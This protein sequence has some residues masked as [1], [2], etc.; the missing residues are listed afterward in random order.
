MTG[1]RTLN[2]ILMLLGALSVLM[3]G[4]VPAAAEV[5]PPPCHEM[6]THSGSDMPHPMPDD[7][8]MAMGCCVACVTAADLTPPVR[9]RITAPSPLPA[10]PRLTLPA[11]LSPAPEPGPPKA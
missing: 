7:A 1:V 6:T 11:G 9:G 4:A 3:V 5:G 2:A 8:V 10:A